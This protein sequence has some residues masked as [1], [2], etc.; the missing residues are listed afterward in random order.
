M[1]TLTTD[2]IL[3]RLR[4]LNIREL[5]AWCN[6]NGIGNSVMYGHDPYYAVAQRIKLG[7]PEL[8]DRLPR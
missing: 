4:R 5:S 2:A 3:T 8:F 7:R 1:R 6:R